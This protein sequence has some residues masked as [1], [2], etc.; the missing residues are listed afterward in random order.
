MFVSAVS[1]NIDLSERFYVHGSIIIWNDS[2]N[3]QQFL[4]YCLFV[5]S[6]YSGYD[7]FEPYVR[8]VHDLCTHFM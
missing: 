5:Y 3:F 1:L 7:I 2:Y 6:H 8:H 4:K